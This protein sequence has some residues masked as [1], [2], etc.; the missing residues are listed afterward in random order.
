MIRFFTHIW[1]WFILNR[2]VHQLATSGTN[3]LHRWAR[4]EQMLLGCAVLPSQNLVQSIRD[5]WEQVTR[6]IAI[7]H[8][9]M[10]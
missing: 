10:N 7:S 1:Y 2:W 4:Q 6:I 5:P 8:E 9:L 3:A